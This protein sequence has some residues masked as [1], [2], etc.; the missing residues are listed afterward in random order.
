MRVLGRPIDAQTRCV[1][2]ATDSDVVAI[3][4]ACCGEFYPCHLCHEETAGH[5]A[6]QW[7]ADQR[8]EHAI[9]CGVCQRTLSID[10]YFSVD[11]C[12]HCGAEFNEGCKLHRH[13]YFR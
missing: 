7:P 4:F 1:H 8:D 2:Y 13:L 6:E 11:A 5:P 3:E 10:S 9:L 12:P